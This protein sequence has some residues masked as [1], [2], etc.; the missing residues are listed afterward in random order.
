MALEFAHGAIQWL[1][2][3]AATTTYTVSGLSFQPKALRFY[4]VG[5]QSA[6]ELSS[7][8]A[9]CRV[10]V[11]FAVDTSNRR[12]VA[13]FSQDALATGS[14]TGACASNDCVI[15]TTDGAGARDGLLDLNSITSDGFTAI[16][17]DAAPVDITVFWEAWGGADIVA[18]VVGDIAEPAAAG[19]VDYTATGMTNAAL[20]Q[21]LFLAG[22]QSV[23]ALNTAESQDSGLC[24]GFAGGDLN[25]NE[26]IVANSD[27]ASA[28][29]DCDGL[30]YAFECLGQVVVAGGQL[31]AR[32][33]FNSWITDGFR[34]E[35]LER[36]LTNRRNIFM[37][38]KGGGWRVGDQNINANG[39]GQRAAISG[40]PFVPK[41]ICTM[42]TGQAFTA[43]DATTTRAKIGFGTASSGSS[44]RGMAYIDVNGVTTSDIGTLIT[45]VNFFAGYDAGTSAS[46]VL[47]DL[48]GT[49]PTDGWMFGPNDVG[50]DMQLQYCTFGDAVPDSARN[51]ALSQ[52]AKDQPMIRGPM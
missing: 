39:T 1:A 44:R 35:W 33:R 16:V 26:V 20:D 7:T 17:D 9:H 15:H 43:Q 45:Y 4:C 19:F 13:I 2:A 14:N 11:G 42:S 31:N 27:D 23:S 29:T 32:A 40:L 49:Q 12:S 52:R 47:L 36:G 24:V 22:V 34:L 50:N 10:S 21:V 48:K 30:S 6:G 38:I 46:I 25:N 28:T 41:G 3:D 8:T 37:A 5:I 51:P 18:A